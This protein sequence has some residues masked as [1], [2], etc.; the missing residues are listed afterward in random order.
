MIRT[1]FLNNDFSAS[2]YYR[3]VYNLNRSLQSVGSQHQADITVSANLHVDVMWERISECDRRTKHFQAD[4]KVLIAGRDSALS[5]HSLA[6]LDAFDA[7]FMA[8][9]MK[10]VNRPNHLE[11]G[12]QNAC[13]N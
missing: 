3:I 4:E 13:E 12:E 7:T 1:F 9:E 8:A 10:A 2:S 6:A 11:H 5:N